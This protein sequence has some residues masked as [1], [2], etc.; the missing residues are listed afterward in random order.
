MQNLTDD[1]LGKTWASKFIRYLMEMK[2]G[3]KLLDDETHARLIDELRQLDN[4]I[5]RR[6][7]PGNRRFVEAFAKRELLPDEDMERLSIQ[8]YG[9]PMVF[10]GIKQ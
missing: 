6:G 9:R 5:E 4:E 7:L 1:Q 10:R 3:R 8:A 2:E